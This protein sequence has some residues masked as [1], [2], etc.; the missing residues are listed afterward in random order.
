MEMSQVDHA[1]AQAQDQD[2]MGQAASV[3]WPM[4]S[5]SGN[6]RV[7]YCS[8]TCLSRHPCHERLRGSKQAGPQEAV[9]DGVR[10]A[11]QRLGEEPQASAAKLPCIFR[12]GLVCVCLCV[13]RS[14]PLVTVKILPW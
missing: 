8:Q 14:G 13:L 5:S 1:F 9:V 10:E 12:Y 6:D 7:A 11:P 3:C 2:A 4:T